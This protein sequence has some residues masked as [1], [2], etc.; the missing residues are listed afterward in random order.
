MTRTR[1]SVDD[2]QTT[3]EQDHVGDSRQTMLVLIGADDSTSARARVIGRLGKNL[4]IAVAVIGPASGMSSI[5]I[6]VDG[7]VNPS[8]EDAEPAG[9]R[10]LS[11]LTPSAAQQALGGLLEVAAS[12][13]APPT[14]AH[15]K[16]PMT[17]HVDTSADEA[18]RMPIAERTVS[19]FRP[20]RLRV[21]GP[22]TVVDAD[23]TAKPLRAK[24]RELAV[25]LA[26]HPDG[27]TAREIGEYL[28][29]DA[30]LKE[31]D[32]RV[33]TNVSNLRHV[34]ASAGHGDHRFIDQIDGRYR[35]HR[36]DVTVDLWD[37]RELLQQATAAVGAERLSLLRRACDV[38]VAPL[39]EDCD[40]EW[41]EPYRET[42][43]QWGTEAHL[44]LARDLLDTE[45][46]VVVSLVARA[47]TLDRYNEELYR[48]AMRARAALG[49][50]DGVSETL[51]ALRRVLAEI[52]AKPEEV[53]VAMVGALVG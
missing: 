24:A 14:A 31:S 45:P 17:V 46:A 44:A 4:G 35:L 16:P 22:P 20:A 15:A 37:L 3:T 12:E 42:V 50:I 23:P 1:A 43:R 26:C 36:A 5:D 28:E 49:D 8:N 25:F 2:E 48:T 9:E 51:A 18:V 30:R 27:V 53:T 39:A 29:P 10:R 13:T 34:L 32:Q 52:D 38:Y 11:L 7:T 47:V 21:L 40:Y 6:D 41:I 19:S 33:H